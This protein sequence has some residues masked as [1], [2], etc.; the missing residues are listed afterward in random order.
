MCIAWTIGQMLTF[1]IAI[2]GF[3]VVIPAGLAIGVYIVT[4]DLGRPGFGG[5]GASGS[6]YWRGRRIEDDRRDRWN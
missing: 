5:D 2:Q 4:D 1:G 3:D 6:K